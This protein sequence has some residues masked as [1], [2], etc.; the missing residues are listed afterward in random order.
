MLRISDLSMRMTICLK[1]FSPCSVW[2][3]IPPAYRLNPTSHDETLQGATMEQLNNLYLARD[4]HVR[5][6]S[7][8]HFS[9]FIPNGVELNQDQYHRTLSNHSTVIAQ[10]YALFSFEVYSNI[11]SIKL[12]WYYLYRK[13]SYSNHFNLNY[14]CKNVRHRTR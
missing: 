8:R 13:M 1:Q 6:M 12:S 5:Q 2:H 4:P 10:K 11:H 9:T 3:G 7:D 14:M